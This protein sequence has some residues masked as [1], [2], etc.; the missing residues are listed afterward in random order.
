MKHFTLSLALAACL[1]LPG[2]VSAQSG[3]TPDLTD[4]PMEELV[5]RSYQ[6]VAMY[7]VNQKIALAEEGMSTRGYNI[8][9]AFG[10]QGKNSPIDRKS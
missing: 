2:G 8:Y 3:E 1:T 9:M 5:K 7:N 6:Y 10:C 4:P